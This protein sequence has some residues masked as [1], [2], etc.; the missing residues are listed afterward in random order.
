MSSTTANGSSTATTVVASLDDLIRQL[1][2]IFAGDSVNVELVKA[3]M[4]AYN[5]KESEWAKFAKF[6]DRKSVV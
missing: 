3:V 4:D 5:S 1:H 6:E 2:E